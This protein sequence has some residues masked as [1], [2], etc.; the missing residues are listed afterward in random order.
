MLGP[1]PRSDEQKIMELE[2]RT[3]ENYDGPLFVGEDLL[4]FN[5]GDE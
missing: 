1:G 5:I 3:R 4:R 2:A